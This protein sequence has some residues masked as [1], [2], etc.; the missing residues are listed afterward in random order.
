MKKP[1]LLDCYCGAGGAAVG[2]SRAGFIV[3]GVDLF[4]MPRYPYEFIRANVLDLDI[5]FLRSFDVIHA[6]PPCQRF[7]TLSGMPDAREHPNLIP[8]TRE[9]L[10]ASGRPYVI[11][12]TPR[13]PLI[14][15]IRL[16]G[17]MFGLGVKDAELRRH[18]MFETSFFV[19]RLRCRHGAMH[20]RVIGVYGEGCRDSRRKFD[21][22][23]PEFTVRDGREAME[24][25]Y[26]TTDE[27]SQ[28]IPQAYS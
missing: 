18:R 19:P 24:I 4:P 12:N 8:A 27:L 2:Y 10:R 9:L 16:C 1:R 17:S 21:R 13:A 3:T 25:E 26:M 28:S 5:D 15:P 6:R 14:D 20:K 11:E 22:S 7:T 23:I